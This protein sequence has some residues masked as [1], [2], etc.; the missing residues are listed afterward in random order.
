MALR[1]GIRELLQNI[2]SDGFAA[3]NFLNRLSVRPIVLRWVGIA[4]P[5][6]K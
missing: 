4:P 1:Q 2:V 6:L 5:A 3:K